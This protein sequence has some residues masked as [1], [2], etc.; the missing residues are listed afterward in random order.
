MN[1]PEC[2][3]LKLKDVLFLHSPIIARVIIIAQ[4]GQYRRDPFEIIEYG[5]TVYVSS[6]KNEVHP[7]EGLR[8]FRRE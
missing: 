1:E 5:V 7:T 3:T 6:V 8:H 4:S 2:L